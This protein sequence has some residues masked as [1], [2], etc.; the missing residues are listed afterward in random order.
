MSEDVGMNRKAEEK[1]FF[2]ALKAKI[3]EFF[4]NT[5]KKN[6]TSSSHAADFVF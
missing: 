3:P 2:S 1:L 6:F 4:M 5:K